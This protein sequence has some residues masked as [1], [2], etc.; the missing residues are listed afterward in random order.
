MK[1]SLTF[2]LLTLWTIAQGQSKK[3]LALSN[4]QI[5]ITWHQTA[6]GWK[7]NSLVVKTS[8]GWASVGTPSG[9]HTLLFSKEKPSDKVD[10][11]FKTITGVAFPEPNYKYQKEQWNESTSPVALNTAGKAYHFFPRNA[12]QLDKNKIQFE[13]DIELG[14]VTTEWSLDT[15]F[16]SDIIVKQ[17]LV[18]KEGGYYSL[19]TQ[20][21]A[22]IS[23]KNFT[24]ATVPG[25]FQGNSIQ[26]NFVLAYA[27]GHGVPDLPVIYRERCASTLSPII[28]TKGGISFSAIP[29][30]GLARDPWEKDKI[31][32]V[33]WNIGL[34]HK[35]RKSELTPTLYFPIL[36]EP[37]SLLKEG[38][39]VNYTFR[40]S[41]TNGDWFKALNHTVYD[42]YQFKESLAL[43]KSKQSLTDRIEQMH[44]YLTDPATS[45]WNVEEFQ[46]LKIGAQSYLGGV[47]GSNRD[48]MKNSDY[49]A[50]WLLA[51]AT[52]DPKLMEGRL[53]Y[54]LNFK[55]AQQQTENGFFRGA[56]V[57]QY[58]LAK[59][60]KFVEEWGEV[61]EPIGL[62][63]Y[64]MLD[65]GNILLF[66]PQNEELKQ[67]LRLGAETLLNWQKND[68]S[69]AVAYDRH[70][71]KEIFN[72]IEDLR[73]SFYGMIVAYRILKDQ[74]YLTAA[75]RGADWLIENAVKTGSFLGV[76]GDA[77]YAPDFATGQSAQAFLD[78]FDLTGE[79]KY[80]DAAVASAKI[81]TTSIYT[82]PIASKQVKNVNGEQREDWEIAQAGLSFEHG[83]IFGSANRHGP[84]MLASHAGL[85]VRMFQLTQ[86]SLFI[87]MARSAAIGRDAF[88][89]PKTSVASYY[90]H[91][92]NR[93]AGPYPHHAWWQIGWLT[94]YLLSEIQLRSKGGISFPQGFVTPKVGSHKSYGFAPGKVFGAKASLVLNKDALQVDAP[95]I[96][97]FVAK[98]EDKKEVYLL[99][100]NNDNE[101][102]N[103]KATI[104]TSKLF[105]N[106][107][108]Q[109][110]DINVLDEKGHKIADTKGSDDIDIEF[111]PYGLRVIKIAYQ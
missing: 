21:L 27:Y 76:C 75:K 43:R 90:W 36:G 105:T 5:K 74:K 110:K 15:K 16:S 31:T 73:P 70:S 12:K 57:G 32:Q 41:L 77:R 92:M 99:L 100:L 8:S 4:N 101:L 22:S 44:H 94:D 111:A 66:E 52:K 59:S 106:T 104:N 109:I 82:H 86:D 7:I 64:T 48:A 63:Y 6:V 53:P 37:K 95:Y 89:D 49:G 83:G 69:W 51:T 24:W 9:E 23:E 88:V 19:S 11:V 25:Y 93:G 96:D 17:T 85:F 97:Y 102:H 65:I 26:K 10:T 61:V 14:T 20:T 68:G 46:N 39:Q 54:A 108:S 42:I 50:M 72:D 18:V 79:K 62:T 35:N 91:T 2:L 28:S 1:Y 107:N 34:S 80:R 55:L 71:Q 13:H 81:Y 33:Q 45:M 78:L 60:K 58:Y 40:Y 3:E 47:V 84:I 98:A 87:D 67:R 29:E 38:D 103:I 56:A 30:P